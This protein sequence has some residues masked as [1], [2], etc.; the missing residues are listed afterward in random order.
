MSGAESVSLA[1][2]AERVLVGDTLADKLWAP[3]VQ[4]TPHAAW[5]V[6]PGAPGRPA[7]LR[8]DDPRPRPPSPRRP[9]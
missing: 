5:S 4:D 9:S 8:F 1:T 7:G 6:L 2:W 3:R